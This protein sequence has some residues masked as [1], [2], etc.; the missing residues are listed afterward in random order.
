MKRFLFLTL[1]ISSITVS[2]QYGG[3]EASTGGFSFVPDFTSEDPHFILSVGTNTDKRLQGQLLSLIR[4][5]NLVPRNAIFITRY[6]FLDK[7]LKATIGTH[8]PA[9]QISDDYQV[10][11]FFAQELRTDYGINEKWRLSTMYLYGK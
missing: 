11:S 7:R 4:T 2:A 3:I 10:D 5:E 1:I 8:L 9:L 6:K